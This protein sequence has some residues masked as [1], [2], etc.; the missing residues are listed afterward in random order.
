MIGERVRLVREASSLTQQQLAELSGVPVGTLGPIENGRVLDPGDESIRQIAAV[1]GFPVSFFYGGPLP[2]LQ[3]GYFRKLKRGSAKDEKRLRAH[4]RLVLEI[5][6]QAERDLQLPPI[7]LV[8]IET[9]PMLDELEGIAEDVRALLGVGALDPIPNLTR[10]VERAGIVVARLPVVFPDHSAYSAWPDMGLGGRPIIAVS[11]GQPGDR[12]RASIGHELG[13]LLLH[14]ARVGVD[15]KLAEKEAFRFAGAVL[16]PREAA[17]EAL[18]PPITLRVLMYAKA[19][20]GTSI[21]FNA[22]RARDLGLITQQ[23]FV[24]LRKQLHARRWAKKEPVEVV[25]ESPLLLPKILDRLGGPGS[26][27]DRAERLHTPYFLFSALVAGQG[28]DATKA[29]RWLPP[30]QWEHH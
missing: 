9:D 15:H 3:E 22:Q 7:R 5:V 30:Q 6:Q 1:T 27:K 2:D 19:R 21:A 14:T 17:I 13:H 23:H 11:G 12:E 28:D 16:F 4:V 20:F 10:A 25:P 18:R 26:L 29:P 24:S 8:P